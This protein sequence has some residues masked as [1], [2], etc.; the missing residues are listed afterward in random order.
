MYLKGDYAELTGEGF[1]TN[2]V[3]LQPK[4]KGLIV[5]MKGTE[6]GHVIVEGSHPLEIR[7]AENIKRI[8]FVKGAD[9]SEVIFYNSKGKRIGVPTLNNAPVVT[10][11]DSESASESRRDDFN[12]PLRAFQRSGR[13]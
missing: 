3:I 12:R 11:G 7:G 9:P 8:D 6:M 5:D 13:R 4:K 1:K 10:K 2:T